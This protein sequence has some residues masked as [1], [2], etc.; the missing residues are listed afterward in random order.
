[1]ISDEP[2]SG[3]TPDE[4]FRGALAGRTPEGDQATVIV[5]RQGLGRDGR[6]WLTFCGAIKTTVV[7]TNPE[8][9]ELRELLG[10]ATKR[11]GT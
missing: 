8:V 3:S 1:M 7:M 6:V 2:R 5:T 10:G 11:G 9:A 4:N